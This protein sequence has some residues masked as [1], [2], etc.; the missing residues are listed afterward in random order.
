MDFVS[1][2]R[3]RVTG[4]LSGFDRLVFH[5][6]LIPLRMDRGMFYFLER[7]GVRLL[8]FKDYVVATSDAVK[9]RS[10]A[11]AE[12]DDRP[13][14][15]LASSSTSKEDT[16]RA[17][18]VDHPID[19]GL[20]CALTTVEP[21]MSFEYIRSQDRSERGLKLRPRKCLHIYKY[22]QHPAFGFMNVRLQTWFPF[23]IQVCLNGREWLAR[24]LARRGIDFKRHDNCFPWLE[25]VDL[26]QRLMDR[27]LETDWKQVLTRIARAINPLH[28]RIFRPWPMDY[29]WSAYQT[30]WATDVMFA[31]PRD[32]AEIYPPLVAHAMS[33]FQSPDVMRFLGKKAH[34]NFIGELTTSFKDRA[35]GVRVK[36]WIA[37]NSIKMYD[38]AGSILRVETTIAKPAPFKVL[39]PK[40]DDRPERSLAWRPLR[41]GIADL[42]R[43][44]EVSQRANDNYLTGLAAVD[45]ATPLAEVFDQVARRV[46]YGGRSARAI[47]I[48]DPADLA[49]LKAI[50]RGEFATAGFRNRDLQRILHPVRREATRS[51]Q[52]RLSAKIGR[53]LRLLRAHGL[54]RKVQRSHRYTLTG[55]GHLLAAALFAMRAA[56]TQQLLRDLRAAA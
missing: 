52:R 31:S 32:L 44:A 43:R 56:T 15:Y 26:A 1:R 33:H 37:G 8:D 40:D 45:D 12:R 16:A 13:V 7:A 11:Q 10:L 27:Q 48:G 42:H 5:G 17:L 54:I 2:F 39:R 21:C 22:F 30:E 14:R 23:D 50:A 4:V 55:K 36:H 38:K 51:A 24:Q 47:R 18:L 29:Y 9:Q 35:E 53:Q 41:K 3:A 6:T 34:G 19:Q 49:L 25:D 46:T 28:D 20:I